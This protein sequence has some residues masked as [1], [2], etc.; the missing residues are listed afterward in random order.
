MSVSGSQRQRGT[1]RDATRRR[2]R[3]GRAPHAVRSCGRR[4]W[5]RPR[6]EPSAIRGHAGPAG[7]GGVRGSRHAPRFFS[8]RTTSVQ[9][10]RTKKKHFAPVPRFSVWHLCSRVSQRF[11]GRSSRSLRLDSLPNQIANQIS[12]PHRTPNDGLIPSTIRANVLLAP[13]KGEL[14][15]QSSPAR[16]PERD[17]PDIVR[18]K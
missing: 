12:S 10:A 5:S 7:P 6:R 14:H 4:G 1:R 15:S 8:S 16:A 11:S 9:R 18:A 3:G 2:R 13:A 17:A